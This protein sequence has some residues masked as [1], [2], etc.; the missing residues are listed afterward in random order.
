LLRLCVYKRSEIVCRFSVIAPPTTIRE[1][2]LH[3]AVGVLSLV[4]L[5]F[6]NFNLYINYV[7]TIENESFLSLY[8][9]R[10]IRYF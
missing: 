6:V 4:S 10:L 7:Y 8:Y 5:I 3:V 1:M 2:K 9:Y